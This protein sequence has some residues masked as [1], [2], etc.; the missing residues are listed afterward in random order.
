MQCLAKKKFR[1]GA[2]CR[3]SPSLVIW[4]II[5]D[6]TGKI[7][8]DSSFSYYFFL[9]G[10]HLNSFYYGLNFSC[11]NFQI[12]TKVLIIL[13]TIVLIGVLWFHVYIAFACGSILGPKQGKYTRN[14]IL[15]LWVIK[16]NVILF[17]IDILAT[18]LRFVCVCDW[19][20]VWCCVKSCP[21]DG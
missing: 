1:K 16:I 13:L 9:K 2:S 8:P 3:N 12:F 4:N 15:D 5:Q 21:R 19:V 17:S 20:C 11:F 18:F 7:P 14:F 10:I 6:V